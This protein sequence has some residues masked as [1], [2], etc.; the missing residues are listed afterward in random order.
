VPIIFLFDRNYICLHVSTQAG[1]PALDLGPG[2]G[3]ANL[4]HV[5]AHIFQSCADIFFPTLVARLVCV[6]DKNTGFGSLARHSCN[7][8]PEL[9]WAA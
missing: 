4:F 5:A 7:F 3:F 8:D 6:A 1:Q 9:P 2:L